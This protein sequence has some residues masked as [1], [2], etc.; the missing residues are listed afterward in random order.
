L[1]V[2]IFTASLDQAREVLSGGRRLGKP[3]A[4]VARL[5]PMPATAH[6]AEAQERSMIRVTAAGVL[7]SLVSLAAIA[8]LALAIGSL[9]W[10]IGSVL[11]CATVVAAV[12]AMTGR[13]HPISCPR[14]ATLMP[15]FRRPASVK[16]A[17]WGGW[18][19]PNCGC[20]IDRSGDAMTCEGVERA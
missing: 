2:A 19:C 4:G 9:A 6:Q 20:E 16:Q 17:L 11:I 8:A 3:T 13:L 5:N 14:C 15:T 10:G 12:M 1:C 7:A 18:S